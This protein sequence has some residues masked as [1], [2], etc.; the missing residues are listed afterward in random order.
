MKKS[1][2][3][4]SDNNLQSKYHLNRIGLFGSFLS[5]DNPKYI[6]ILIEDYNDLI[7]FQ[8]E[9]E[10]AIGKSVDLVIEKHASSIIVYKA[11]QN[12]SYV[13]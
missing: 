9:L 8:D 6:N 4:L 3:F 2:S 11:K 10:S 1:I 5:K 12:I 7:I 13:S